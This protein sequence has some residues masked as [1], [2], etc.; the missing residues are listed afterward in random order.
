MQG[1]EGC[2][3]IIQIGDQVNDGRFK[4][5]STQ[6]STHYLAADRVEASTVSVGAVRRSIANRR[7]S[8]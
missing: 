1:H 8:D 6:L 5:V 4:I 2:G 3:E 7:A